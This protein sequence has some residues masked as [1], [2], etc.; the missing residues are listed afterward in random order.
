MGRTK[1]Y[2]LFTS[3]ANFLV[4]TLPWPIISPRI[5]WVCGL[6]RANRL[7]IWVIVKYSS[8]T[9]SS[10]LIRAFDNSLDQLFL[11]FL[12]IT[13]FFWS[14]LI[15]SILQR[16]FLLDSLWSRRYRKAIHIRIRV[17][18]IRMRG[19]LGCIDSL[20]YINNPIP[21]LSLE[22]VPRWSFA[23]CCEYAPYKA[24]LRS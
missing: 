18:A 17:R 16:F 7:D 19:F 5:F 8:G 9:K 14:L 15:L 6:C 1:E 11:R 24:T 4:S 12:C 23:D 10:L 20:F 13:I 22:S 21:N 2:S 3:I